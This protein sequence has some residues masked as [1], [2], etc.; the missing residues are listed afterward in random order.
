MWRSGVPGLKL[1]V[2]N[3]IYSEIDRASRSRRNEV[4]LQL[5]MIEYYFIFGR[6]NDTCVP[7]IT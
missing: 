5:S 3:V 7:N 1:E 4:T 2:E 6:E